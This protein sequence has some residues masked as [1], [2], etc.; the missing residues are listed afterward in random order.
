MPTTANGIHYE[1]RGDGPRTIVLLPGFGCSI[2]CWAGVAPLLD[3][4]RT[5]LVDLPGHAGSSGARADGNLARLADT[6]FEAC[7]EI[8]LTGF[9][10]AGLSLGGAISVRIAL[11]H[12]AEVEAVVGVMPWNAGGTSPGDPVI[13]AFYAAFGDLDTITAGVAGISHDPAKTTDLVRTMPTVTEQMWRGW[14]GGGVYTSMAD[15]LP[16]LRV[17]LLYLVGGKDV[18]VNLEKQISDVRQVP[19]GRLVLL[20]DAGHLACYETPEVVAAEMRQFLGA[21]AVA[22]V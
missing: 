15:E 14:L 22:A 6:V 2:E 5:V 19:G 13:E 12:P 4:Y 10:V 3:G 9:A 20:A 11:D 18:V 8:G 7:R 17:P 16:G 1:V 21:P